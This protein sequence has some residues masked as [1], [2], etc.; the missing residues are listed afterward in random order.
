MRIDERL[1]F[2]YLGGIYISVFKYRRILLHNHKRRGEQTMKKRV[3][4]VSVVFVVLAVF[5]LIFQQIELKYQKR[6]NQKTYELPA[7]ANMGI[8]IDDPHLNQKIIQEVKN[9]F[10]EDLTFL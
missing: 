9:S 10:A 2:L 6:V 7:L 5:A 1:I 3:Y 4:F 8:H